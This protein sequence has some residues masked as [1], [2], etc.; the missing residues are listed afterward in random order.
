[1]YR[2]NTVGFVRLVARPPPPV[3]RENKGSGRESVLRWALSP[4]LVSAI[5][6]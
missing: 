6:Q 4:A 2:R 1:M 5:R 3:K